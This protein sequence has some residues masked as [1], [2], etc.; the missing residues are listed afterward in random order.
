[1]CVIDLCLISLLY[2][3]TYRLYL[4]ACLSTIFSN[5]LF[6]I[7]GNLSAI[8]SNLYAIF[9][10]LPAM[11]SNLFAI[12]SNLDAIC[13]NQLLIGY[14]QRLIT[15]GGDNAELKTMNNRLQHKVKDINT[16]YRLRLTKYVEDIAVSVH[17]PFCS[18]ISL[19]LTVS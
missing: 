5:I 16:E 15:V 1:M 4:V 18:L 10:N 9:S 2:L 11:C 14:L 3:I 7:F 13:S 12:F 6:T 19:V 8:F 17:P